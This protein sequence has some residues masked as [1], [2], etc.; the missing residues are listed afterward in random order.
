MTL[1]VGGDLSSFFHNLLSNLPYLVSCAWANTG[2]GR[3][4]RE[5]GKKGALV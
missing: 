1:G 4:S 2:G 5:E 3:R